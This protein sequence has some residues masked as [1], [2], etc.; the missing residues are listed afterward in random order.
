ML[1]FTALLNRWLVTSSQV[2]VRLMAGMSC[3]LKLKASLAQ[4]CLAYW[5]TNTPQSHLLSWTGML[6]GI[7]EV[8]V[9]MGEE[10]LAC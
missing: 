6:S 8:D 7:T 5:H 3:W 1:W 9:E 4:M 2:I 10:N